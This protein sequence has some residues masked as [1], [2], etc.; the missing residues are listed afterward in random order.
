MQIGKTIRVAK[1]VFARGFPSFTLLSFR[2]AD[3][4][5]SS[6]CPFARRLLSHQSRVGVKDKVSEY[7]QITHYDDVGKTPET[8]T[9][10]ESH[11]E[12]FEPAFREGRNRLVRGSGI[13]DQHMNIGNRTYQSRRYGA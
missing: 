4:L 1:H 3:A 11:A 2:K 10:G 5:R 8:F 7:A 12:N 6:F 9:P 13:G